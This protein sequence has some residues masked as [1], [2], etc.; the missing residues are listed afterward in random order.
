MNRG[1]GGFYKDFYL[2]SSYE[3]AYAVY[4]DHFSIPWSYEDQ[5]FNIDGKSYKP[6]FFFY[7]Q[8]GNLE[9][10]VEIKSRNKKAKEKALH[11]LK[12]IEKNY[13]I[14]TELISYEELLRLYSSMPMTLNF[15]INNWITSEK[16]T[17]NKA[18]KGSLN[19]HYG[20]K[21]S[22]ES[23]RKIGEHTK[24]LWNSNTEAK[25]TYGCRITELWFITKRKN[26]NSS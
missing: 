13:Q 9:K 26:E 14:K 10:I 16:T 4:L 11:L 25:K 23:K 5:V 21:H 19:P 8:Y 22:E 12:T 18:T 24:K 1:Y 6:D 3:Y 2:R 20:L 17:I 7:N 15:I